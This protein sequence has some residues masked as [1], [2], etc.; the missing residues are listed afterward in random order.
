VLAVS[1]VNIIL[2]VWITAN[3]SLSTK[4]TISLSNHVN[5]GQA[6]MFTPAIPATR[7]AEVRRI[8]VQGQQAKPL[9]HSVAGWGWWCAAIFPAMW[10]ALKEH[11]S[12]GWPEQNCYKPIWKIAKIIGGIVLMAECLP[13]TNHQVLRS[14]PSTAKKKLV[15]LILWEKKHSTM[16][17]LS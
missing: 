17:R 10:E 7:E 14:N 15:S 1:C 5:V 11:R 3:C 6:L 4:Y 2:K 13:I 12:P 9:S 8:L 16:L